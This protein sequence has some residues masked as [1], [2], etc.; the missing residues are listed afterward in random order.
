MM[1]AGMPVHRHILAEFSYASSKGPQ[2][3]KRAD[4]QLAAQSEEDE[5]RLPGRVRT[6]RSDSGVE[7]RCG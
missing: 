6:G 4:P 7:K 1:G 5:R 2:Y 3:T